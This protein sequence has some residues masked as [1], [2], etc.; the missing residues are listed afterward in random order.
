[1]A[2]AH[3]CTARRYALRTIVTIK[4]RLYTLTA[5]E[6]YEVTMV[7]PC[8][9][10]RRVNPFGGV[11]L[12]LRWDDFINRAH[13]ACYGVP[14]RS[15][16]DRSSQSERQE[17]LFLTAESLSDLD[18]SCQFAHSGDFH[19]ARLNDL[20][21]RGYFGYNARSERKLPVPEG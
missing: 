1:M 21:R 10:W 3:S 20:L 6:Q 4:R 5:G 7:E 2:Q 17:D 15:L 13:L 18:V 16:T 9:V 14:L 11:E 12:F 19:N 8:L